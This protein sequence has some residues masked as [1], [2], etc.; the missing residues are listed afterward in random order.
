MKIDNGFFLSYLTCK[1]RAYLLVCGKIAEQHPYDLMLADQKT[2]FR[3]TAI[4]SLAGV[5]STRGF[6]EAEHTTPSDLNAGAPILLDAIVEN[7]WAS[8]RFD[9]LLRSDKKPS[10]GSLHYSPVLFDPD[11][12]VRE[13]K[14]LLLAFGGHVLEAV[15]HYAPHDG[16]IVF[17]CPCKTTTVRLTPYYDRLRKILP[18]LRAIADGTS[19]PTFALNGHCE[20]CGFRVHCQDKAKADDH[21]SL[22]GRMKAKEIQHYAAKGIFTVTQLSYTFR[23]RRRSKRLRDRPM[24]HSLALQALALRE[25]KTY[26]IGVPQLPSSPVHVYLDI[27]GDSNGKRV[28]L[29]GAIVVGPNVDTAYSF[30]ADGCEEQCTLFERL[31]DVVEQYNDFRVFHYG[32]YDAHF[33]KRMKALTARKEAAENMIERATNVLS[34]VHSRIYFPTRTNSLKEIGRVLGCSWTEPDASG[35]NTL[36]WRYRWEQA[37]DDQ[38]KQR[39]VQYNYEDC[40]ALRRLTEVIYDIA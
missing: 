38:W 4:G 19:I 28:Y 39:L 20:T 25:N 37:G 15:H 40:L 3:K 11:G 26:V 8:F 32:S 13:Q 27:E 10:S 31:L 22:L 14:K 7:E 23:P 12:S 17:G 6:L 18:D 36:V 33:L 21:L 5:P 30:W 2:Q 34:L 9:A 16:K 35:L 29:I 24:P 1:Y